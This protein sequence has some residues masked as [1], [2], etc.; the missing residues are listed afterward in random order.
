MKIKHVL[1]AGI[2][3]LVGVGV[4]RAQSPS[5]PRTV[6]IRAGHL[7]DVK[8]GKTLSNQVIIIQDDKIVSVG[9]DSQIPAGAQVIDLS[10]R[11]SVV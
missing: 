2:W 4:T 8:T 6:A 1:I 9:F 10:D 3:L 5:A 7:L 11:K